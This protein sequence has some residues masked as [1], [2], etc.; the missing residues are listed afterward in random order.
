MSESLLSG[1][2]RAFGLSDPSLAVNTSSIAFY[3]TELPFLNVLKQGGD[4]FRAD[5][6]WTVHTQDADG[7]PLTL[8]YSEASHAGYLDENGYVENLP[9]GD[10]V[11]LFL[12]NSIPEEAGTGGRYVFSYEG[13]GDFTFV[14]GNIVEELSE[15]GRLVVDIDPGS[16]FGINISD[17]NDADHLRDFALVREEH[18]DLYE[19]GATFNPDF[20]ELFEDH[21]TLR[22]VDWTEANNSNQIDFD[23]IATVDS[24]FYG[25]PSNQSYETVFAN[26][27][28]EFTPEQLAELPRGGFTPIFVDPQTGE[29]FR[30]P[31]TNE[32]L[33]T[34]PPELLPDGLPSG[35][36]LEVLVDLANQVGADPWFN[37]PH[38]ATDEFVRE[39]AEYVRDNL[40][41]GLVAHFEY[42]NEVWNGTF[43]Q[44]SY[45]DLQGAE[46][47]ADDNDPFPALTFYGYRS[48][49][50]LDIVNGVYGEE[51]GARVHGILGTQT[52][53]I[54][55]LDQALIGVQRYIDRVNPSE[56][57]D[58]L[59]DSVAVT[60]YF[61]SI[62][63]A[64]PTGLLSLYREWIDESK[65]LFAAGESPTLYQHFIDQMSID[66]RT[67]E[68]SNAY[69]QDLVDS[70]QLSSLPDVLPTTILQLRDQFRA[71]LA[72]AEANGLDLT[73]YEN[74]SHIVG[75]PGLNG[76]L[77]LLEFLE[78]LHNSPDIALIYEEANDAFR[79][80]GGSLVNDY[81]AVQ[82]FDQ[83]GPWGSLS[84]LG[85]QSATFDAYIEYNETAAAR[86]GSI[87]VGRD[88]E[89]FLQGVTES[90]SAGDDILFGT[91][92]EDFLLGSDGDDLLIGGDQDDGLNG[93]DGFD[94]ALFSGNRSDYTIV[95]DGNGYTVTGIDGV[96]FIINV[97]ALEFQDGESILVETFANGASEFVDYVGGRAFSA[98]SN[99][100]Q[101]FVTIVALDSSSVTGAELG[102]LPDEIGAI[103]DNIYFVVYG[104]VDE[105]LR[106]TILSGAETAAGQS[107]LIGNASE[108]IG[109]VFNDV[110][111]GSLGGDIVD[112]DLGNDSL[113]G[114]GGDDTISGNV[115]DDFILGGDGNDLLSGGFGDD[116]IDGGEGLDTLALSGP[117]TNFF[118]SEVVGGFEIV[119]SEGTDFVTNIELVTF[120]DGQ[121]IIFEDWL[122]GVNDNVRYFGGGE[123]E[124]VNGGFAG[125]T[126]APV[127]AETLTGDELGIVFGESVP[128]TQVIYYVAARD[129]PFATFEAI[130]DNG[131]FAAR[132][133]VDLVSNIGSFSGTEFNDVFDGTNV[134]EN[135]SLG[136]G[137]DR[138]NGFGG[139][140]TLDG[141]AGADFLSG[142]FGNDV[143]I[144]GDGND[145]VNGGNGNDI[146]VLAGLQEDYTVID[147]ETSVVIEGLEGS[148]TLFG[149]EVIEFGDGR[150]VNLEDW[151]NPE[152][153]VVTSLEGGEF[154]ADSD[155]G[156]GVIIAPIE[157]GTITA[158]DLGIPI[159][160]YVSALDTF[161][162]VADRSNSDA[163]FDAI[164][165]GV[166]FALTIVDIITQVGQVTGTEFDDIFDG[167]VG[168]EFIDLGAGD[169]RLTGDDGNDTLF[170]GEGA[171]F[172]GGGNGDDLLS[173]GAGA[174]VI[175]GGSGHDT[176]TFADQ[177]GPVI[178]DFIT[179]NHSGDALGDLLFDVEVIV[180]TDSG[181]T[182]QLSDTLFEADGGNGDDFI[183]GAAGDHLLIGGL[184][185]DRIEGGDGQDTLDGG[186]GFDTLFGGDG[187]DELFG[188]GNADFLSGGDGN[189]SLFGENGS[190]RLFGGTGDDLLSGG[191]LNDVLFG[192]SGNDTLI[193]GDQNDRLSGNAGFDE[194]FGGS[195]DDSL[196]GNFNADTL[197]GGDGDDLLHGGAGPN[198]LFG[199]AGN[200]F[201][202][203]GD[204]ND[205]F[206]GGEGDDHIIGFAGFDTIVGGAGNDTLEGRFNADTFIFSDGFG[207]DLIVDFSATNTSER[208]DL[209]AV[210]NITDYDDL[211]AS[212]LIVTDGLVEI[213]DGDNRIVLQD[214]DIADLD[215]TDFIF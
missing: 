162:S 132:N 140:D 105:Q 159:T 98:Q 129:N 63:P 95:A 128:A 194:L 215:A 3:S 4:G 142:G 206:D 52:A 187:E 186:G 149:V 87:N 167:S 208:I 117:R 146:L 184:G 21:R 179:G 121:S 43:E 67:G 181:D 171:D 170:G 118:V 59:F 201:L 189:D 61:G 102:I 2:D 64:D 17:V 158:D 111:E 53:N 135:V 165:N 7:N 157:I 83:F 104:G 62:I 23:D 130:H 210:T 196:F 100:N 71:N 154:E 177:A 175:N 73:Q 136:D 148:D 34:V 191:V 88:L 163:T 174:D 153:P 28:D 108:I 94:V 113:L 124:V 126:I 139:D 203:A 122:A 192:E 195:G 110:F 42:S 211:I 20:I 25:I 36:P 99:D 46:L 15:P 204:G 51:A 172:L 182:I 9:E 58:S 156:A 207:V 31:D 75:A 123:Y 213:V 33:L 200:D 212:H 66:L 109:T 8:D 74:G 79:E 27:F 205:F 19:A 188:D 55:V 197:V 11:T 115:G 92:Q 173:G 107:T 164:H 116:T 24:A 101:E 209:S 77:E 119:G 13:E 26:E 32:I 39:F 56:T 76:D 198:T 10:F 54:G 40:D 90:G 202:F 29:P 151:L 80:E 160:G 38:G 127:L 50:V 183:S 69:F 6:A 120:T 114:L 125:V 16:P 72:I 138:L 190:D 57:V 141:G 82:Q 47:F 65:A 96:D 131:A 45:A 30:D 18:V 89:A 214:V 12:F 85:D 106:T 144:A 5:G 91:R 81:G 178:I 168:D 37:I 97:E 185:R 143:L 93:G 145:V 161:F 1:T 86:F 152:D 155:S 133:V 103:T 35:V 14:G 48:A 112:G 150:R 68:L 44:N 176:L 84:Y 49:E 60:G 193:G 78:A 137:D 147:L 22:F 41:P 169:D 166:S 70:G 199:D 134:E 180:G